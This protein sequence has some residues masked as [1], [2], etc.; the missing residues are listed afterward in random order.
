MGGFNGEAMLLLIDEKRYVQ[1]DQEILLAE[2]PIKRMAWLEWKTSHPETTIYV[3]IGFGY[4]QT[5]RDGDD[6]L[7]LGG[8]TGQ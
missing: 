6:E 7:P 8:F 1:L 2:H 4:A 5:L 3:G